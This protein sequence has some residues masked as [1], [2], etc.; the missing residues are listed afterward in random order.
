MKVFIQERVLA[1]ACEILEKKSTV[2][3]IAKLFNVS[4]STVHFDL[5]RRLK[6]INLDLFKKV[7][8]LLNYNL[9]QRHIRGGIATKNKY[10][11]QKLN[12]K[13]S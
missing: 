3:Q 2:R 12:K 13:I 9:S 1:E 10:Y 8:V 11:F 4:K 7:S 6:K 5:S